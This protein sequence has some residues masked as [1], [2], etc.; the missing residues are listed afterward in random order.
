MGAVPDDCDPSGAGEATLLGRVA[1]TRD[2]FGRGIA[3]G[4]LCYDE[5]C[6]SRMVVNS[7]IDRFAA[8]GDGR[9][10]QGSC[11]EETRDAFYA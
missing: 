2:R 11:V 4:V 8:R 5:I 9:D 3:P 6:G 1:G 7:S 10:I